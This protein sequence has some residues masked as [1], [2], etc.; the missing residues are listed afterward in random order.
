MFSDTAQTQSQLATQVSHDAVRTLTETE[1]EADLDLI[2]AESSN[3][4]VYNDS[5]TTNDT[6]VHHYKRKSK[7]L[8]DCPADFLQ[9]VER[10]GI[11]HSDVYTPSQYTDYA[12][13]KHE[14]WSN[15][16]PRHE[17]LWN[18][19]GTLQQVQPDTLLTD[20]PPVGN[21]NGL[22]EFQCAYKSKVFGIGL[23]KT[24]T[25]S[26]SEALSK[27]GYMDN[28]STS[29]YKWLRPYFCG[30]SHWFLILRHYYDLMHSVLNINNNQ[31]FDEVLQKSQRSFNFGDIPMSM[32]WPFFDRWYPGSKYIL[33]VRASTAKFV[34]SVMKF[35]LQLQE[36]MNWIF[37][38][39]LGAPQHALHGRH[40]QRDRKHGY[41]MFKGQPVR[42]QDLGVSVEESS[43][44]NWSAVSLRDYRWNKHDEV[45]GEQLAHY[46]AMIYELHNQRVLQYFAEHDKMDDE[47]NGEQLAHYIA[48]IY[49]LHNQRVLQYFAEHDK[50]DD[51]LILNVDGMSNEE[52]W[53][54]LTRF[55]ECGS[56][57]VLSAE[58]PH[59]N[60]TKSVFSS[61]SL[62][63]SSLELDWKQYFNG[64]IP[65]MMTTHTP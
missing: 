8:R 60:P 38:P 24:G 43:A 19:A 40:K 45:N 51:L 16:I 14:F 34:N 3:D 61:M 18:A 32:F 27:L 29:K 21:V 42:R 31:L 22:T 55:L 65:V 13:L 46:I 57:E 28:G 47:V 63:P 9:L 36:C 5:S 33:T 12:S 23:Y 6:V 15:I 52:K 30:Y 11:L 41:T 2:E 17:S 48:M 25:T 59:A 64:S 1:A 20:K 26:L 58:Y 35:C 49:E 62:L 10:D 37:F 7:F 53:T 50:M 54:A 44:Y 56:K 39:D 4:G